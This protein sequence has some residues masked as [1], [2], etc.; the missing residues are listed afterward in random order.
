MKW[1]HT[2]RSR[3][4]Y[5]EAPTEIK[6]AFDKQAGLLAFDLHHPSLHAKKFDE[7]EDLWQARVN[8]DWRFYFI[9]ESDLYVIVAIVR[10]PK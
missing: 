5:Q 8:G 7:S 3:R 9:I 10:H 2:R 6:K 4:D 1:Q